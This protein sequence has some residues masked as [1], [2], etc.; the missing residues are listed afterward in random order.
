MNK[1]ALIEQR[2]ATRAEMLKMVSTAENETRA[3][4]EEELKAFNELAEKVKS[5]TG[6]LDAMGE[7]EK[8]EITEPAKPNAEPAKETVEEDEVR[9]FAQFVRGEVLEERAE[10]TLNMTDNGA[11]LPK[12]IAQRI[13]KKVYDICPI[14]EKAEKYNVKGTL[15]IPY[16]D[17][18]TQSVTMAY[19]T[20]FT[21]LESQAGKFTNI[22]L[23]GFLA[24]ALAKVSKS[25][26]N[27]TDF[28]VVNFIVNQM[29]ETIS[30]FIEKELLNGTASKV[31][32]LSGVNLA[33]ATASATAITMDEVIE[34]KDLVKDAFQNNAM[35]IMNS[36]TRTKLRLLKD[37]NGR[38]LMQDDVNSPFG[39][40]LLGKPVYVTD[41]MVGMTAGK[42]AIYYG[43]FSGLA[44]KL[45]EEA[46]VEVL[47][48][49]FATQHAIGVVAWME[50]DSKV[51]D[52]QK[53]AKLVMKTA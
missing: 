33:K 37:G 8:T 22:D 11:V 45:S 23:T 42:T 46:N 15:S 14:F 5:I 16:Y 52:A 39:T 36:D 19:A 47:R 26:V 21:E 4:T 30:R 38:Y 25:L 28:D 27:N 2:L 40:T 29:A 34:L 1:K 48:E 44:V 6:T 9:A 12:T 50:F 18:S 3:M 10:K 41:N 43:D 20:D 32:G 17:E 49:K 24:G 51:Q 53:I 31:A 35:F 7:I 13:I